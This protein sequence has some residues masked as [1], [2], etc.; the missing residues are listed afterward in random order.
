MHSNILIP[1]SPYSCTCQYLTVIEIVITEPSRS[2]LLQASLMGHHHK[3]MLIHVKIENSCTL[4][5]LMQLMYPKVLLSISSLKVTVL[6]KSIH[7]VN[8]C[9][10]QVMRIWNKSKNSIHDLSDSFWFLCTC[11]DE[12]INQKSDNHDCIISMVHVLI[13]LFF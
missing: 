6:G 12:K 1:F 13:S 2:N 5:H 11:L 9:L 4:I 7:I 3:K 8:T 10:R